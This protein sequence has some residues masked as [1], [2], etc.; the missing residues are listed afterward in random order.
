MNFI[1]N[2]LKEASQSGNT[3]KKTYNFT[4]PDSIEKK[5]RDFAKDDKAV[6]NL[7]TNIQ[8]FFSTTKGRKKL[9][10]F[11]FDPFNWNSKNNKNSITIGVE[12][13]S[14]VVD[15]HTLYDLFQNIA[16]KNGFKFNPIKNAYDIFKFTKIPSVEENEEIKKQRIQKL[17]FSIEKLTGKKVKLSKWI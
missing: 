2:I 7:L 6:K 16:A 13:N 4:K 11:Y 8:K 17:I 5:I 14:E 10:F 12:Y 1:K 3:K 9:E 15:F